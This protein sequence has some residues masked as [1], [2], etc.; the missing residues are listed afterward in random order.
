MKLPQLT[1]V[2]AVGNAEVIE[3][4]AHI[5]PENMGIA[6]ALAA[7]GLYLD[8]IGSI[9]REI[10]SNA[11]DANQEAGV[12]RPVV[13]KLAE[14][15]HGDVYLTIK[16]EGLG[17]TPEVI[18]KIYMSYYE[19]NKR[20][21]DS[22]IGGF[23]LGSK[24]PLSYQDDFNIITIAEGNYYEYSMY[25]SVPYNKIALLEHR[26]TSEPSGTTIK[27][28]LKEGD[29]ENFTKA[30]RQQLSYF[31]EVVITNYS[32]YHDNDFKLIKT[33]YFIYR[34]TEQ[35][36]RS[37]HICIGQVTYPI[38][39]RAIGLNESDF[40][41]PIA[42]KFDIGELDITLSRENLEY[43]DE[44]KV[45]I[46]DKIAKATQWIR[47]K[48]DETKDTYSIFQFMLRRNTCFCY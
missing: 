26:E 17:M 6:M 21:S 36:Y 7:K 43:T 31:E 24:S 12:K 1:K 37:F 29:Q 13:V 4:T 39:Y 2:E 19:S 28:L 35:P 38:N 34:P 5:T 20:Q 3:Y 46:L 11:V 32:S 33:P 47:D 27:I 40:M 14:D 44:T 9:V 15:E 48:F 23:G 8:P 25:K 30:F 41:S 45:A 42:L 10:T 18:E 16:D 22:Q